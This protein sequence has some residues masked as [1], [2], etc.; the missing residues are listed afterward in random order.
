[1]IGGFATLVVGMYT[2]I[3][4]LV[5][6]ALNPV[7]CCNVDVRAFDR[8]AML[9]SVVMVEMKRMLARCELDGKKKQK[10][11]IKSFY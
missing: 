11:K 2:Y 3:P 4:A 5:G 9:A 7:T 8:L 6:P 1:M 10:K